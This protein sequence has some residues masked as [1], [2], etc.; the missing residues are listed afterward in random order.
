VNDLDLVPFADSAEAGTGPGGPGRH[1][2]KGD[3]TTGRTLVALLVVVAVLGGI[4]LG[5]WYGVGKVRGLLTA[6]DYP[7]PGSGQV[8]V[9]VANDQTLTDIGNS[10]FKVDVIKSA[11]A[12]IKA[13]KKNTDAQNI[14]PGLYRLK[15]QMK[16]SDAV[17]ALLDTSSKAQVTVTIPE[18]LTTYEIMAKLAEKTGKPLAQFQAAAADPASLGVPS[19]G[20]PNPSS[21]VLEGF[22]YP[23]TY[24]F[25]INET[26]KQ[27]LT[28]MVTMAVQQMEADDISG[29]ATKLGLKPW[30][31]LKVASLLQGEGIPDDFGKIARVV[32]NRLSYKTGALAYLQFDSTTQYWLIKTGKGRRAKVTDAVL[33]DPA[34]NYSTDVNRIIGLPPTPISNPGKVALDAASEPATGNWTYFVVTSKDGHSSFTNSYH[35]HEY[36]NV[37]KCHAINRC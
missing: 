24:P 30:D 8:L 31:L 2:R 15:K 13:A 10:L 19:W 16:A 6:P 9:T 12:F 17:V 23:Q 4:A 11:K 29:R 3:R 37:P 25:P 5:G 35:E 28:D 18:G 26:P 33:Q 36:V 1:R 27:M 14:Q 7:G 34:N 20:G 32:Y 22:L 21:L